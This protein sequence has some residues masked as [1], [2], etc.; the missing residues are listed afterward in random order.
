MYSSNKNGKK[1]RFIFFLQ[2]KQ[3]PCLDMYTHV[4]VWYCALESIIVQISRFQHFYREISGNEHFLI[5]SA[6]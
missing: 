6:I 3:Q 1:Q 2:E 4:T 5:F